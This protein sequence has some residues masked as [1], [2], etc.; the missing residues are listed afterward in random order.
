M[1]NFLIE[2]EFEAFFR[3]P[4]WPID[5]LKVSLFKNKGISR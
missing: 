1:V 5:I 3:F 2:K 4:F